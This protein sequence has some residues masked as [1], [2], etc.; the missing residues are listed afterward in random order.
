M[1]KPPFQ[2]GLKAVFAAMT[3]VAVMTVTG[4]LRWPPMP[5]QWAMSS[6]E[7]LVWWL[8][9]VFIEFWLLAWLFGLVRYS[10]PN[11]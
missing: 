2:F 1:K 7:R 11:A 5:P 8:A 6:P 10:R 4:L 9:A 3:L